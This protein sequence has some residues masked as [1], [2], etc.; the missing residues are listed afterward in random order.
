[1]NASQMIHGGSHTQSNANLPIK[2][3]SQIPSRGYESTAS[4][5]NL[6]Y[7]PGIPQLGKDFKS[8][9]MVPTTDQGRNHQIV[10]HDIQQRESTKY[11]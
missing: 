2:G 5:S 7:E 11:G 3:H 1:M 10:D 4:A 6:R 9:S 8:L